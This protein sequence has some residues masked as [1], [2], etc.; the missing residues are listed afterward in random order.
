M[1]F[2]INSQDIHYLFNDIMPSPG[3]SEITHRK[4]YLLTEF[5]AYDW[6]WV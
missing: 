6:A 4:L 1:K 5:E 2:T 3:V